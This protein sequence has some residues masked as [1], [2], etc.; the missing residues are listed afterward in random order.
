MRGTVR[1]NKKIQNFFNKVNGLEISSSSESSNSEPLFDRIPETSETNM[2]LVA[3]I[4]RID[5]GS[6]RRN[7]LKYDMTLPISN[8]TDAFIPTLSKLKSEKEACGVSLA[9]NKSRHISN[10]SVPSM[11]SCTHQII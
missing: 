9:A 2:R 7:T 6:P 8:Q 1:E 10:L 3:D 5:Q 11:V 4:K